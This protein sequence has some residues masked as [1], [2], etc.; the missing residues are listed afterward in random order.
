MKFGNLLLVKSLF[1]V[2]CISALFTED[3]FA[4]SLNINQLESFP[5]VKQI[6]ELADYKLRARRIVVPMG[7]EIDQHEHSTRPGIVY[8]ESGEIVEYRFINNEKQQRLLMAGDTLIEDAN[9]VHAYV[10][11]S[12]NDCVLIA[13]DLPDF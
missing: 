10:N 3:A 12:K 5:L 9:T 2:S 7:M 8:V 1:L 13:I 4:Q 11:N 6:P